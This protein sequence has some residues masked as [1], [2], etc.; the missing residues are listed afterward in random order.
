MPYL[1]QALCATLDQFSTGFVASLPDGRILHANRAAREMMEN[2]GPIQDRNGYVRAEDRQRSDVLL[3]YLGRA[4]SDAALLH[5]GSVCLHVPLASMHSSKGVAIA[6]LKPL[7]FCETAYGQDWIIGLF[8]ACRAQGQRYALSGIAA[9]FDL[10][11]AETRTLEQLAQGSSVAET[12]GAL[13]VSQN[14]VKTH[15]QNIFA[16]T[17]SSRQPQLVRLVNE[18]RPPLRSTADAP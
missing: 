17:G 15:L 12:A 4:A 2:D 5:P 1:F 14:T 7:L 13:A 3:G 10:T 11:P 6:T 9:C 16:K 8:V 18:L